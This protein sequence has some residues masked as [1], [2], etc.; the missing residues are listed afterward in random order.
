MSD[1]FALQA[2]ANYFTALMLGVL[3]SGHC[4]GMCGGLTAALGFGQQESRRAK[5]LMV[6]VQLGRVV[7]YTLLGALVGHISQI[8][9][10]VTIESFTLI[11]LLLRFLAGLLLIAMGLYLTQWWLGI[12]KL[13]A[14]GATL[15]RKISPLQRRLLPIKSFSSALAVGLLWGF[16]PCGL[17]YSTLAWAAFVNGGEDTALLMFF[18]GLGTLPSLLTLIFVSYQTKTFLQA[19]FFKQRKLLRQIAGIVFIGLGIWTAAMVFYHS[20][21]QH[22]HSH[23]NYNRY[24]TPNI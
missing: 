4:V 15:W 24:E 14:V 1:W 9:S 22:N 17:I 12:T 6:T 20:G 19:K 7:C 21:H 10:G 23:K 2:Q 5:L 11:A 16:I 8:A 18:F 13:E 3:A